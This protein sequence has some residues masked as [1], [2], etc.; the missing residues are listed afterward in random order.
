M[1]KEDFE[2]IANHPFNEL[3]FILRNGPMRNVLMR[4]LGTFK[5]LHH[6]LDKYIR[7]KINLINQGIGLKR[8][9]AEIENLLQ[10]V[11]KDRREQ[12]LEELS[13]AEEFANANRQGSGSDSDKE[14]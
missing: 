7:N 2:E 11:E 4:G 13:R 14:D 10:Y 3:R 5:P 12:Y 8:V 9:R 6:R 1:S